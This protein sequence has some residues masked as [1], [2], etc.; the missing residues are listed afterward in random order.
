MKLTER[1]IRQ[2]VREMALKSYRVVSPESMPD[3]EF[4]LGAT[5]EKVFGSEETE[6]VP[7]T[8]MPETDPEMGEKSRAYTS[9]TYEQP[10]YR[11]TAERQY[12]S[13]PFP[14]NIVVLPDSSYGSGMRVSGRGPDPS[15]MLPGTQE[16]L[17]AFLE[18]I[19]PEA[20]ASV[21]PGDVTLIIKP[22]PFS[23]GDGLS[24]LS[25]DEIKVMPDIKRW[26][27]GDGVY[28]AIHAMFEAN[29][30]FA[31]A[32]REPAHIFAR[33]DDLLAEAGWEEEDIRAKA[34]AGILR[35]KTLRNAVAKGKKQGY[36][37]GHDTDIELIVVSFLNNVP[38][39]N[40][41]SFPTVGLDG[42]PIDPEIVLEGNGL[43]AD[44]YSAVERSI[45][46]VYSK[47]VGKII[48]VSV[49]V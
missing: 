4:D 39:V 22:A 32:V 25:V 29:G 40:L 16:K 20:A 38:A 44:L 2:I 41:D 28:V 35:I 48:P 5:E 37:E 31:Y 21:D 1:Q 6:A 42:E 13:T 30:N 33:I 27:E 12:K 19:S 46:D 36:Y 7:M 11:K 17:F 47:V 3:E 9:R 24:S 26:R 10:G 49:D 15:K 18:R 23:G 43:I 8:Y 14:V 34:E 45:A